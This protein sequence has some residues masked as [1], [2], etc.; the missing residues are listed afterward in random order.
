MPPVAYLPA[1][2]LRRGYRIVAELSRGWQGPILPFCQQED[3]Q[4]IRTLSPVPSAFLYITGAKGMVAVFQDHRLLYQD[5]L[6]YPWIP[7]LPAHISTLRMEGRAGGIQG[8]IYLVSVADTLA[9]SA[10]TI[11]PNTQLCSATF[12][13]SEKSVYPPLNPALL[14]IGY[15]LVA[16]LLSLSPRLRLLLWRSYDFSSGISPLER[17]VVVGVAFMLLALSLLGRDLRMLSF[18]GGF[19]ILEGLLLYLRGKDPAYAGLTWIL[20]ALTLLTGE[21]LA[22]FSYTAGL[23]LLWGLRAVGFILRL[24]D[25]VYLCTAEAC[26]Y[27][28]VHNP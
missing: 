25:F 6:A 28:L 9:W 19:L 27:F 4:L 14:W 7:L 8:G 5:T 10:D 16:L 17:I 2:S 13:S 23:Y 21:V 18:A 3:W 24:R 1:D 11:P 15:G 22:L 20:P 26:L 12:I